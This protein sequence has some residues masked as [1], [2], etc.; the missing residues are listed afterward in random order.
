MAFANSLS[1]LIAASKALDVI[2][3]NIANSQT[4]GFKS[5]IARF[6][7][8]SAA[9]KSGSAADTGSSAGVSADNIFQQL[10][11]GKFQVSEKPLDMAISGLGFFRLFNPETG[12]TSYT[13]DGQFS[14]SFEGGDN[15]PKLVSRT[16]LSVTGNLPDFSSDPRGVIATLPA[17]VEIAIAPKFPPRASTSVALSLN[18]DSRVAA[19]ALPFDPLNPLTYNGSATATVYDA[20]GDP[21]NLRIYFSKPGAASSWLVHTTLDFDLWVGTPFQPVPT[22]PDSLDFDTGGAVS[23][24]MPMAAWSYFLGN[25]DVMTLD[26]DFTGSVQLGVLFGVNSLSQDGYP[27]GFIQDANE[28][29]VTADGLINARYSNGQ[30]RNV[31]QLVLAN[32]SNANAL[33]NIGDGQWTTNDDPVRGTGTISLGFPKFATQKVVGFKG[34]SDS[35]EGMGS[36]QGHATEQSNI[37]LGTEL[38]ALIEQQRNYQASAQTFKILDQVL[39]NLANIRSP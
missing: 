13:R 20:K 6:T 5:S 31:A 24:V 38:V 25:G 18:L 28:F 21:H 36:I 19:P 22:G 35:D 4:V 14:L 27:E 33:V 7:S 37:D 10:T 30:R 26:L 9:G 29:Q 39:Q 23:S 15:F 11:Q 34:L 17:P 8:I 2:G 3:N 16:G 32:F 1:G 12:K